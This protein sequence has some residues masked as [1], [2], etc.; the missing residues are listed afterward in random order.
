MLQYA[1]DLALNLPSRDFRTAFIFAMMY[2]DDWHAEHGLSFT[3]SKSSEVVFSRKRIV[4][5]VVI[6]LSTIK[7]F[8]FSRRRHFSA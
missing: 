4:P 5:D 8:R 6:E 1:D 7:L 2:L 3:I